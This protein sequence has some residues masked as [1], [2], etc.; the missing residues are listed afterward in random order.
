MDLERKNAELR[1]KLAEAHEA[2]RKVIV[3]CGGIAEPGVSHGFLLN[4][5]GEVEGKLAELRAKLATVEAALA[6]ERAKLAEAEKEVKLLDAELSRQESELD[7][8]R[9]AADERW[10]ESWNALRILLDRFGIEDHPDGWTPEEAAEAIADE[11]NRLLAAE[12][13]KVRQ[14]RA[15]LSAIDTR[16]LAD[17]SEEKLTYMLVDL[18][19]IAALALPVSESERRAGEVGK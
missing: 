13:G 1:A 15:A 4:A 17:R 19:V 7:E 6:E 18:G 3:A 10:E 11:V 8:E 12:A 16:R 5:P 9:S 2:L 14:M